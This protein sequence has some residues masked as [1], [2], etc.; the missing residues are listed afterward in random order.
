MEALRVV[1]MSG[2]RPANCDGPIYPFRHVPSTAEKA[3]CNRE[4]VQAVKDWTT[5]TGLAMKCANRDAAITDPAHPPGGLG[6]PAKDTPRDSYYA[7]TSC[8]GIEVGDKLSDDVAV[9]GG[10]GGTFLYKTKSG[11]F[12]MCV[13][14]ATTVKG[15]REFW[16]D[17]T[18]DDKDADAPDASGDEADDE[19][20]YCDVRILPV[21]VGCDQRRFRRLEDCVLYYEELVMEDWPV[22]GDR[23]LSSSCEEIAREG[24]SWLSHRDNWSSHSGVPANSRS[25]H[26]HSSLC[27]SGAE[28]LNL[29]RMLIEAAHE[30]HPETPDWTGAEDYM[31]VPSRRSGAVIDQRRVNFVAARQ[32]A[33]AKIM[34]QSRKA[35]EEK[36]YLLRRRSAP[37]TDADDADPSASGNPAA[38]G[39]A[40]GKAKAAKP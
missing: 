7:V 19:G 12:G 26:E 28:V 34:E 31:G 11:E 10:F 18:R 35:R 38:A 25:I 1:P 16:H 39:K 27:R 9:G 2:G 22:Q 3:K 32:G 30:E 8:K 20:E 21:L 5:V 40:K 6:G 4:A 15:T 36:S 29:R 17:L 23:S 14:D 33:R 13:D 37:A 24:R